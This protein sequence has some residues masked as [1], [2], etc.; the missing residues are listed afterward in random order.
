CSGVCVTAIEHRLAVVVASLLFLF[1]AFRLSTRLWP[2]YARLHYPLAVRYWAVVGSH[3]ARARRLGKRPSADEDFGCQFP[4][5]DVYEGID[6][7]A[8]LT[9]LEE[10]RAKAVGFVDKGQLLREFERRHSGLD[11]HASGTE[12]DGLVAEF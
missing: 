6:R 10:T 3:T 9:L 2:K 12:L 8:A 1:V 4:C 7:I 5:E 11:V